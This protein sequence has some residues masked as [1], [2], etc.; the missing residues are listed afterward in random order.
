MKKQNRPTKKHC[1]DKHAKLIAA[2]RAQEEAIKGT[3]ALLRE[4]VSDY[5]GFEV[6]DSVVWFGSPPRML[7]GVI[8]EIRFHYPFPGSK[9]KEIGSFVV[10][11]WK[12]GRVHE[13]C[14]TSVNDVVVTD[15]DAMKLVRKNVPEGQRFKRR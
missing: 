4:T 3:R 6:G 1:F 9:T 7:S 13:L 10:R 8:K 15:R 14:K 11:P 12:K 5:F 2:L